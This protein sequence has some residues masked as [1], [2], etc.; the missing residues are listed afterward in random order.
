[1]VF[2][3]NKYAEDIAN[4]EYDRIDREWITEGTHIVKIESCSGF[5]G[6]NKGRDMVI[7]EGEIESSATLRVGDK[8]KHL[9]F[10]SG[11]DQWK[12]KRNLQQL[13]SVVSATLPIECANEVTPDVIMTAITGGHEAIVCGASIKIIAK[14]K[15][16]KND[17][18]FLSFSFM[19]APAFI[20][21]QQNWN[22]TDMG[23]DKNTDEIPF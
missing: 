17:K 14:Q 5:T 23:D 1:M 3:I 16:S 6:Q 2:D 18:T 10:L 21:N 12:I 11:E 20:D 19:R 9:W 15:T 8:V 7:L 22:T 13:K 4:A